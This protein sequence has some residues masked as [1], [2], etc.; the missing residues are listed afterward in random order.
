MAEALPPEGGRGPG[1]R[2]S[3]FPPRSVS[4]PQGRPGPSKQAGCC[5]LRA[6]VHRGALST[7]PRAGAARCSQ[8]VGAC[9][10]VTLHPSFS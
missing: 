6:A 9:S 3:A 1:H 8:G 2:F 10:L 5:H 4:P 7:S